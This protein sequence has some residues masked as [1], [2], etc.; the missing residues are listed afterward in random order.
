MWL[1]SAGLVGMFIVGTIVVATGVAVVA[2]ELVESRFSSW[3]LT[4]GSGGGGC[5]ALVGDDGGDD[6][7]V[8]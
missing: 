2:G 5:G 1:D 3:T 7:K 4:V 6:G 8:G